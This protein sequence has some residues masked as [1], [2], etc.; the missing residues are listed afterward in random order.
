MRAHTRLALMVSA[1]LAVASPAVAQ[2]ATARWE[3]EARE[4]VI[5]CA[6]RPYEMTFLN[7]QFG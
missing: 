6:F 1:S 7:L 2:D 5:D 4:F 3:A